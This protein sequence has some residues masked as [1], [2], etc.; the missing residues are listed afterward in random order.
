MG[1]GAGDF[2]MITRLGLVAMFSVASFDAHA[3][4][5]YMV[6]G[7]TCSEVKEALDRDGIAVLYRQNESGISLYDRFVGERAFC[8]AGYTTAS[9]RIAVADTDECP[10]RKCIEVRRFGG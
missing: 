7:M 2:A 8:Q 9:E 5:R 6:Q 1:T 4:V 3:I 10:V